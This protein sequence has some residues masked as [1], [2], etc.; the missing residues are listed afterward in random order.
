MIQKQE[1]SVPYDLKPRD[2][3]RRFVTCKLPT[4]AT[5]QKKRFLALYR[6]WR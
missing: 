4:A 1:H 6:D 5:A 2:I 3:E